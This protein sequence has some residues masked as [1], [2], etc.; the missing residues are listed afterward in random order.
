VPRPKYI[1]SLHEAKYELRFCS[2]PNKQALLVRYREALAEAARE[3]GISESL[4]EAAVARDFGV[5]MRQEKLP[6]LSAPPEE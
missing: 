6:R 3:S 1:A 2:G 5:W 4:I